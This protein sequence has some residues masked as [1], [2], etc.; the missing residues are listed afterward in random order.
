[1]DSKS[2]KT[3][4]LNVDIDELI[5]VLVTRLQTDTIDLTMT[6]SGR[7]MTCSI[8]KGKHG[9]ITV[10][11]IN[12]RVNQSFGTVR[13]FM[14]WI[15]KRTVIQGIN[16]TRVSPWHIEY[17]VNKDDGQLVQ[18]IENIDTDYQL[19]TMSWGA[20]KYPTVTC[21]TVT[22]WQRYYYKDVLHGIEER[23]TLGSNELPS[24]YR[25][26]HH[27]MQIRDTEYVVL[28]KAQLPDVLYPVLQTMI[29]QFL[30]QLAPWS[31]DDLN[32]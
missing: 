13:L 5:E 17:S 10:N 27:G 8:A 4:L 29:C 31:F 12:P 18:T 6:R 3:R 16:M 30:V 1:M 22:Y 15:R 7:K 21:R 2:A 14:T 24:K 28:L 9:T 25:Y 11:N 32:I 19:E 26:H 23:W 20:V